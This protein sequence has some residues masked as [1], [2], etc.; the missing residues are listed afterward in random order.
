MRIS[1]DLLW[2]KRRTNPDGT[3]SLVQHLQE[4]RARLLISMAAVVVTTLLGVYWYAHSVLGIQ[5]LGD[6]L[7]G[8]Y[9]A[10]DP[11]TRAALTPDGSCRLFAT[12]PFEQ[13]ML[14]LKV[15]FTAGVV[16]AAPV[17]LY[18]LW[19][20]I[21]PGLYAKERR[22]AVWFVTAG[23]VL[24]STGA[25]LAYFVVAHALSFLLEIGSEAQ[26]TALSGSEYFGLF[27][28]AAVVTPQDPISM[29]V[30][31]VALTVLFEV[32]VQFARI[33]DK[34]RRRRVVAEGDDLLDDETAS[35]LSAPD[36]LISTEPISPQ[37]QK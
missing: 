34:R 15:G 32:A 20:F 9:C 4:L 14:R 21:T 29:L 7:L 36:P 24:F 28:F 30:L 10:L 8:P 18:Q 17:W 11:S 2:G 13:F 5:S 35:E 1:I 37:P 22:Y 31:A 6:V 25:V 19:S 26:I 3:M 33:N 12:G 16:F 27:V 23:T